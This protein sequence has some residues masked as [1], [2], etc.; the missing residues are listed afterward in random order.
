MPPY[1]RG[2]GVALPRA[3]VACRSCK[4]CKELPADLCF[5]DTR[6]CAQHR[7]AEKNVMLRTPHPSNSSNCRSI[8]RSTARFAL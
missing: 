2:V 4:Y 5:S 1:A 3:V 7:H 6:L 8:A